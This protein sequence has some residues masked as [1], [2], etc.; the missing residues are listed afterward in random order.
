MILLNTLKI[1]LAFPVGDGVVEGVLFG[2]EEVGVMVDYCRAQGLADKA[3]VGEEVGGFAEGVGDAGEMLGGVDVAGEDGGRFDLVG[4]AVETGGE[5]GGVGEVGVAVGAR[6]AAF[7]AQALTL[8]DDAEAG[9]AVVVAPGEARR[10]PGSVL[11]PF[12]GVHGGGVKDHEFGR[13][14]DPA[15]QEVAE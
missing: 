7:D 8:P 6:N 4:D 10:R 2:A 12:V 13:V 5:G 9:G 14:F 3:A 11:E 1:S 15:A